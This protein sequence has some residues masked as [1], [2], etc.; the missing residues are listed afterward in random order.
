[1]AIAGAT[2]TVSEEDFFFFRVGYPAD[3]NDGDW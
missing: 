1:M 3:P 2:T